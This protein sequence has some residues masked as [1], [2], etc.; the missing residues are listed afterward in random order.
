MT[1]SPT[2]AM[3]IGKRSM[4]YVFIKPVFGTYPFTTQ[5]PVLIPLEHKAFEN[6][7]GKGENANNQHFSPF[8]TMF[9]TLPNTNFNY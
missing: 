3:F 2:R 6:I 7:E 4:S 5:S 1:V 9:S 8:P